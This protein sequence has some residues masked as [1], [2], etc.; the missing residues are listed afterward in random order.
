VFENG[1]VAD[2]MASRV[3]DEKKRILKVFDGEALYT[4]DYQA[5]TSF[6]ARRGDGAVPELV[7]TGLATERRDTLYEEIASFV[8]CVRSGE[9]PLVTGTEGRRALALAALITRNIE[10]GITGFVPVP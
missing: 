2:V 10:Q 5:Q 6:R 9:R 8:N 3:S 7:S 4:A 1:C